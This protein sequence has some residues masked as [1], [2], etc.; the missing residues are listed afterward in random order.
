MTFRQCG[1]CSSNQAGP[2]DA[3]SPEPSALWN[4]QNYSLVLS[5]HQCLCYIEDEVRLHATVSWNDSQNLNAAKN[6]PTSVQPHRLAQ[7]AFPPCLQCQQSAAR[8]AQTS[9]KSQG[10]QSDRTG[11]NQNPFSPHYV[12]NIGDYPGGRAQ[13][14]WTSTHLPVLE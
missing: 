14:L 8:H 10:L 5:F 7:G 2:S 4:S 9:W 13:R 3:S 1:H 6:E 12:K 11:I